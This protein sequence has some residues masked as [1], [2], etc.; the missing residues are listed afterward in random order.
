MNNQLSNV[1]IAR[2][3][4]AKEDAF[5]SGRDQT[6]IASMS[7]TRVRMPASYRRKEPVFIPGKKQ[8]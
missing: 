8:S 7:E 1:N 2:G 4:K 5:F 6:V 3:L